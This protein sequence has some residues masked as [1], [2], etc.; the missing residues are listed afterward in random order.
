MIKAKDLSIAAVLILIMFLSSFGGFVAGS[1]FTQEQIMKQNKSSKLNSNIK[2]NTKPDNHNDIKVKTHTKTFAQISKEALGWVVNIKVKNKEKAEEDSYLNN[3]PFGFAPFPKFRENLD[4]PRPPELNN[5]T[6][7]IVRKDGYII[8]NSH[9]V[10]DADSIIA[11]LSDGEEYKAKTVGIDKYTDIAVVKIDS[12]KNFKAAKIGNSDNLQVGEW[13][14]AIG[15]SM[16]YEK[17]VTHGIISALNRKVESSVANIDFIQTDAAINP[18]NSGGPLINK[19]GEVI[20]I[21]TAVRIDAQNISFAI[22]INQVQKLSKQLIKKGKIERPWIGIEMEKIYI[23]NKEPKV[24]IKK[25]WPG[26]P[27]QKYGLKKGDIILKIDKTSISEPKDIQK[28]VRAHEVGETINFEVKRNNK[29]LKVNI[30]AETLPK[31]N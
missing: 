13:V 16:G 27:A 7:I 2:V 8:T 6:G 14:L 20:G 30:I 3:L 19:K 18:G 28:I 26:S 25:V 21:N 17:T 22:P 12:D 29:S 4:S 31:F 5:G 24:L 9:V 10:K 11:V 23:K 1:K 15:N